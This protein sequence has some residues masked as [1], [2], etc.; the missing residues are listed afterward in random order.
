MSPSYPHQYP[1]GRD[2][3]YIISQPNGTYVNISFLTMGIV[4]HDMYLPDYIELRDG[5]SENSPLM[6]HFCGTKADVPEFMT[7]TTN[8]LRIR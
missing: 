6:G 4:C 2:C 5:N 7:T 1:P 3:T 8:Y